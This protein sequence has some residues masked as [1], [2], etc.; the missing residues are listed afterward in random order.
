[1]SI[2]KDEENFSSIHSTSF[3]QIYIQVGRSLKVETSS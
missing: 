1:L 3:A 2:E